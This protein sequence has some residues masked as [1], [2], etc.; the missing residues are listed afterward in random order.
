MP[1]CPILGRT[2]RKTLA[3][4]GA[5]IIGILIITWIA[6]QYSVTEQCF[7]SPWSSHKNWDLC[8][9]TVAD[10]LRSQD[11][12][13]IS[14]VGHLRDTRD[15]PTI[16]AVT[17]TYARPVQK[18]DLT[19]LSYTFALVSNLHWIVVEDAT[20]RS[21]LV[22]GVLSRSGVRHTHLSA[23]TPPQYRQRPKDPSWV[24]PRGVAQR[25]AALRWL[26][27]NGDSLDPR[28]VVYFADDDNTYDVRL[29]EEMRWTRR[30]SVWPVALVGGL[31]VERPLV[32]PNGTVVG[33]N[34]VWRPQRP[35][36]IDMA[37]FAV[38]LSLLLRHPEAEFTAGVSRGYQESHLIRQ[39]VSGLSELEPKAENCSRVLVWH[40][41]TEQ[42]KL[43]QEPKLR[44]PSNFGIEV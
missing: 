30:V 24:R 9:R 42:P 43:K 23:A 2:R 34:A 7:G 11:S 3:K 40:T 26:R 20:K 13:C 14:A 17:P 41:R 21:L 1:K 33:W 29:F 15:L 6:Q 27:D 32:A 18:A 35:Y 28:G 31:S 36:P 39:L 4:A 44:V 22:S 19:R 12:Q 16:Y 10:L 25:N 5:S 8:L 37:G 38:A